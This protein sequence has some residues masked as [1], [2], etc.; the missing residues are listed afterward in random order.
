MIALPGNFTHIFPN[1]NPCIMHVG[2]V[3]EGGSGR[4]AILNRMQVSCAERFMLKLSTAFSIGFGV[5]QG[6][7]LMA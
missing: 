5:G 2:E 6:S 3:R 7:K 1:A 4:L